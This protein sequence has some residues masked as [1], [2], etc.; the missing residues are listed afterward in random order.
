MEIKP[1]ITLLTMEI[2]LPGCTSLKEKR[3]R[4]QPLIAFIQRE[5]KLSAAEIGF[6]DK[7]TLSIIGCVLVS[8][9][10]IHNQSVMST[11]LNEVEKHFPDM[12]VLSSQIEAR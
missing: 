9:D 1:V 10:G 2:S 7:W 5:Y 6:L 8:N 4:L 11:V 3:S 12:E